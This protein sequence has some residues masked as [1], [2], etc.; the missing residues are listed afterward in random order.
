[1]I[2]KMEI[3]EKNPNKIVFIAKTNESFANSL[4]RSVNRI[5][6]MAIDELHIAKNDSALYDETVSH[7]MGLIPL[8]MEKG[9]KEGDSKKL[10]LKVKKAGI[11]YSGEIKGDAEVVYPGIPI[12]LINENQ[13]IDIEM[14]TKIGTGEEHAKFNPGI[15]YYRNAYEISLDKEFLEEVKKFFP[16]NEVKTKGDKIILMDNK[17]KAALDFCEALCEKKGL[18]ADIKETGEII[19]TVESFGQLDAKDILESSMDIL[20]KDLKEFTKELK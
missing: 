20:E 11:V 3:I 18:K 2:I 15:I 10:K 5:P 9:M 6:I 13:E 1:M 14:K 7:R 17:S 8:K 4:R 16:E 19:F 12:L